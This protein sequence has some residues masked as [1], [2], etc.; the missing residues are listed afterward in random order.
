M[1]RMFSAANAFNQPLNNWNVSNVL[2]MNRMFAFGSPSFN[3]DLSAWCVE[4]IPSKPTSFDNG[5]TAW[6][7]P[8]SRPDWGATC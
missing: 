2:D 7:L 5:A 4:Q 8:N 6:T 3:Q 1:T